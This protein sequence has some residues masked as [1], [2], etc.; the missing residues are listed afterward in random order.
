MS[1]NVKAT[2]RAKCKVCG[3]PIKK[4]TVC[5]YASGYQ[6]QGHCHKNCPKVKK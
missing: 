2:G 1:N 4:D 5:I 6:T 3:Q